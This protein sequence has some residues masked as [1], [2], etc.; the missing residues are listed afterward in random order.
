V[1]PS[2]G[3]RYFWVGSGLT[4]L[5]AGGLLLLH[6]FHPALYHTFSSTPGWFLSGTGLA[7]LLGSLLSS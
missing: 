6:P 5:L 2:S 1:S 3:A 4:L 7:F